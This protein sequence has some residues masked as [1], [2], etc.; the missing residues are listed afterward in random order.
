MLKVYTNNDDA[1]IVI[2][3]GPVIKNC[4]GFSIYRKRK[5]E[6]DLEA[7]PIPTS[8]GFQ[9]DA[10][11][12]GE[13]RPSTEWPVQKFIWM[14][15]FVRQGDQVAYKV[16]PM[17]FQSGVLIKDLEHASDWSDWI[18]VG[19]NE[20]AEV[21][22]NRGLVSSQFIARR[23]LNIPAKER[24]KQLKENL[25][26]VNS[27]IR[28]F[29]GG[30]LVVQILSMLDGVK[31]DPKLQ[32]Y[33]ALYELEEI[34]LIKK[35][36]AIGK[37]AHVILANGAFGEEQD[38]QAE[39]AALL[40]KVAL[41]RR[42]VETPHFAHNKFAVITR[43]GANGRE[44]A[45]KVFTGS[46][47]WT[48]N[49]LFTQVNNGL[50]LADKSVAAYYFQQ[51]QVMFADCVDGKGVYGK[52]FKDFN[53]TVKSNSDG[54]IQTY[55]TP[56][57]KLIDMEAA[58]ALIREAKQGILFLM[59]KPGV[60]G[61]SLMLYDT[62]REMAKDPG[63]LV[64]GVM[65]NDPGGAAN[66]TITFLH[67]NNEQKGSLDVVLPGSI[68]T[69]FESWMQEMGKKNVTIHS[70]TIVIDPFSD[71]PVII[72]GS[73][74]MGSKASKSNDDNLNIIRGNK[75]LAVAYAL[76][77]SSVYHH[78]RWRFYRA[79]E[80][81]L[82]KW[83]GNVK[84]DEWQDWYAKGEKLKEIQFWS[85]K[86]VQLEVLKMTTLKFEADFPLAMTNGIK[87]QKIIAAYGPIPYP[88]INLGK[89]IKN[90]YVDEGL[91]DNLADDVCNAWPG[92]VKCT[93]LHNLLFASLKTGSSILSKYGINA[94]GVYGTD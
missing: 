61:K 68:D 19:N 15:Y 38:P 54:S 81:G 70:K 83:S 76:H 44:V 42:I 23:L 79:K 4:W 53:S 41:T 65:N 89:T 60:E 6:T 36:N 48:P 71:D 12:D 90:I 45:V 64:N 16:V 92:K 29:M 63:L 72:I 25:A 37:R 69:A 50:V 67:K 47:N 14:D 84:S 17:V 51:W 73:H 59:F 27:E 30:D 66:P 28:I 49:G 91:K 35:L 13:M 33:L 93:E 62:I 11:V 40:T 85:P 46:T 26:D 77:M 39:S 86:N 87:M 2:I 75:Q 82:P 10:H 94:G 5:G 80:T 88:D 58:N 3:P 7:E 22:F 55:F 24:A 56:V 32:I 34:E 18:K 31:A 21:Y 9:G 78:Y 74:N 43:T 1:T 57:P 20:G 8:V 52:A